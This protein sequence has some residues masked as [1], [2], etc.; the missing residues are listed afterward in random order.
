VAEKYHQDKDFLFND[1]FIAWR[2]FRTEEQNLYWTRFSD[3]HPE[4]K[5][6]LEKAI[7]KFSAIKFNRFELSEPVQ[8]DLYQRILADVQ[9]HIVRR[10]RLTYWSVAAGLALLLMSSFMFLQ[11]RIRPEQHDEPQ[12]NIEAII[13][14]TMPANDIHLISGGKT[15][16]L[17]QAAQVTLKNGCISVDGDK[18]SSESEISL[19]ENVMNKLVVPA[20]KRSTLQLP[21]G[22]NVWLNSETEVDFPS[23]FGGNTREI[24]VKGEIYIEV[25]KAEKPFYV[26]ASQFRVQVYGTKF[27]LSAY[28]EKEENTVVLKE[29]S[30]KIVT[31]DQASS[32]L[33][34]PNQKATISTGKIQT[35][36]VNVDEYI[37]WKDGV[38]I[39]NQT[40][41]LEVLKKVGRYYNVNFEDHSGNKLSTKTCTGKLFLSENFED[42]MVSMSSLSS[43]SYYKEN[44]IIYL[45]NS[46]QSNKEDG[47]M[48]NK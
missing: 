24:S 36:N 5:G 19:S 40:P 14:K 6:A 46:N 11:S 26:N 30:V 13:G 9:L 47:A 38:M 44:D 20:G 32:C 23:K 21:D 37:S 28:N 1:K 39:F 29:G 17:K 18:Q 45:I 8:E 35:E 33:L 25:A 41:I 4:C 12:P 10:R 43:T 7:R 15:V 16:A 48:K 22:T 2:L 27:N 31:T 42:M 3:E 34:A